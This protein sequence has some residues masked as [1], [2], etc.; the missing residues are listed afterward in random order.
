[1]VAGCSSAAKGKILHQ[2]ARNKNMAGEFSTSCFLP[3][4]P[5]NVC[6]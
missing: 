1:M 2:F 5:W 3:L 6:V 4:V